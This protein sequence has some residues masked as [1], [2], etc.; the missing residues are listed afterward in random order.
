MCGRA[1]GEGSQKQIIKK[2][3]KKI[4]VDEI[5]L[6]TVVVNTWTFTTF[7][8]DV[9]AAATTANTYTH[10]YTKQQQI[11]EW[12]MNSVTTCRFDKKFCSVFL[13]SVVYLDF[14]TAD[15][16]VV[17]IFSL[18]ELYLFF[19]FFLIF[20]LIEGNFV[21]QFNITLYFS[22]NAFCVGFFCCG[23][24]L[25]CSFHWCALYMFIHLV[26]VKSLVKL[27]LL[28]RKSSM[29]FLLFSV[30]FSLFLSFVPFSPFKVLIC[31]ER[32]KK[33]YIK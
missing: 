31:F 12:E 19:S 30:F 33:I 17:F 23:L 9:A 27:L 7:S 3:S 11:A 4:S 13:L 21:L 6:S 2:K 25:L 8:I 28:N 18:Y 29:E 24:L 22:A 32:R 20:T 5:K 15:F 10:I 26:P 1:I 14:F 16:V